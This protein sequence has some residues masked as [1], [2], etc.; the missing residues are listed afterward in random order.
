MSELKLGADFDGETYDRKLDKP[1][2]TG[3]L[4]RV[5]DA[6]KDGEWHTLRD[7]S[8]KSSG[9]EASVSARIRDLRKDKFGHFEVRRQRSPCHKGL[10]YYKLINHEPE[11]INL[12]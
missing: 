6:M 3:M 9:S 12:F 1:R 2:L 5:Y 4:G 8:D 10:F 7:L 11:Q